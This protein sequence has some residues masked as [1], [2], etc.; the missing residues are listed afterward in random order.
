MFWD[1]DLRARQRSYIWRGPKS[2][3]LVDL[4]LP[5]WTED[6]NQGIFF[7]DGKLPVNGKPQGLW[8]DTQGDE[9]ELVIA[10]SSGSFMLASQY[11]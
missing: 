6:G 10:G 11:P 7:F 2:R 5:N 1:N 8:N 4:E 9:G 3:A